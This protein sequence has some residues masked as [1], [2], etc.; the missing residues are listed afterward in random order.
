MSNIIYIYLLSNNN[1]QL[2]DIYIYI[3]IF[4]LTLCLNIQMLFNIVLVITIF[5]MTAC[6]GDPKLVTSQHPCSRVYYLT[7][8]FLFIFIV[9]NIFDNKMNCSSL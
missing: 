8:Y 3:Y 7:A 4:I 9:L 6:L 2:D 1:D 5:W